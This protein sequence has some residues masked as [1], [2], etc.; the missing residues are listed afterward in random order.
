[1]NPT[2]EAGLRGNATRF[3]N[4]MVRVAYALRRRKEGAKQKDIAAELKV[5]PVTI[6]RYMKDHG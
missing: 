2:R 6:C 1:M 5:H 4:Y 3:Q